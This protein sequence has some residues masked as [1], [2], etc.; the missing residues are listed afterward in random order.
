[1]PPVPP[2]KTT[3]WIGKIKT[4]R[5]SSGLGSIPVQEALE[6]FRTYEDGGDTITPAEFTVAYSDLLAKFGLEIDG[7][8]IDQV[9]SLFD[10]DGNS[11][12]DLLELVCGLTI[13][14]RGNDDEKL[15]AVFGVFDMN[16]DGYISMDEMYTFLLSVFKVMW[17]PEV[18][19]TLARAGVKAGGPQELATA[20]SVECFKNAD[21]NHDGRISRDEFSKWFYNSGL[22]DGPV[23][24]E[25]LFRVLA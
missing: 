4:L 20:T 13:L 25:P 24:L 10:R 3:A 9:F 17:S 12:V 21:L 1:M 18:A 2:A 16:N 7:A 15:D 19:S 5:K 6:H 14:C 22:G 23:G 8:V 11:V